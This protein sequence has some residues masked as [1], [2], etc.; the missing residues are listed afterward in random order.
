MSKIMSIALFYLIFFVIR[1]AEKEKKEN[2]A[3]LASSWNKRQKKA[4]YV[5]LLNKPVFCCLTLLCLSS[6]KEHCLVCMLL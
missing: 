1:Q 3:R 4:A 6:G 5:C 2:D